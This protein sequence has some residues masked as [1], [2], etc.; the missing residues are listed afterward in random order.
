MRKV[1][2]LGFADITR[3]NAP[4]DDPTWE[5]WG[6]GW[7]PKLQRYNRLFEPHRPDFWRHFEGRYG[8][9]KRCK[10]PIYM[11]DQ[12]EDVPN[13]VKYPLREVWEDVFPWVRN[14]GTWDQPKPSE[15][16]LESSMAYMTA[17][18]IHE[19]VDRIGYW[20]VDMQ[21]GTGYYYERPNIEALIAIARTRGIKV[22]VPKEAALLKSAWNSGM[23]GNIDPKQ[24]ELFWDL[25]DSRETVKD[26]LK[27]NQEW[28]WTEA[29][30]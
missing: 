11:R 9:Y 21:T 7:D 25:N 14:L 30:E 29:A 6:L 28:P 1:A 12:Y 22:Y 20:G 24:P 8:F 5:I 16:I 19:N 13:S 23:Y 18:A 26:F 15:A 10:Q 4:V 27:S 2:L 17:L 3:W